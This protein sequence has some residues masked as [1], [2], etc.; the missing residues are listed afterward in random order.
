M[1]AITH[2]PPLQ[3]AVE[4]DPNS[5]RTS[6]CGTAGFLGQAPCIKVKQFQQLRLWIAVPSNRLVVGFLNGY[7]RLGHSLYF[8]FLVPSIGSKGRFCSSVL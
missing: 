4:R 7:D 5:G 6:A 8:A 2:H 1:A 3:L